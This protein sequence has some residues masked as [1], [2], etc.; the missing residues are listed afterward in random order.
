MIGAVPDD[1]TAILLTLSVR[2]VAPETMLS[3]YDEPPCPIEAGDLLV[4]IQS[5]RPAS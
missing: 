1:A 3:F 5:S 4:V 2:T